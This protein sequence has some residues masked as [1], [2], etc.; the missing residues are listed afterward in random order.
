MLKCK[1]PD[2]GVVIMMQAERKWIFTVQQ[3]ACRGK[4]KV[5]VDR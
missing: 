5:M 2:T 4:K 3:S 1:N